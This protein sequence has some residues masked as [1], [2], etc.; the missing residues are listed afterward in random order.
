METYKTSSVSIDNCKRPSKLTFIDSMRFTPGFSLGR[1]IDNLSEIDNIT[2][3]HCKERTKT[4]QYCEFSKLGNKRLV[5]KCLSCNNN[6]YRPLQQYIDKFSNTYSISKNSDDFVLLL[7]KGIF[8][9]EHMD[10]WDKFHENQLP[11]R[12]KFDSALNMSSISEKDYAHEIN[13]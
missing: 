4:T 8:P 2:C 13:V 7:R 10:S 12:D 11:P 6:S 3:I 5:Y 9:Y 1:L